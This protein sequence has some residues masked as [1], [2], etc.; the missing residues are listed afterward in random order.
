MR[1]LLATPHTDRSPREIPPTAPAGGFV[2]GPPPF[3][4]SRRSCPIGT[5][6]YS[7]NGQ[8][9]MRA[10]ANVGTL[11]AQIV[12][13]RDPIYS[14]SGRPRDHFGTPLTRIMRHG[15]HLR[16]HWGSSCAAPGPFLSACPSRGPCPIGSSTCRFITQWGNYHAR[17]DPFQHTHHM[18]RAN[19]RTPPTTVVGG[20]VCEPRPMSAHPSHGSCPIRSSIYG[21][22]GRVRMRANANLGTP[23]TRIVLH[24]VLRW[25]AGSHASLRRNRRTPYT[26]RAPYGAP[27]A[28][29]VGKFACGPA[30]THA[31]TPLTRIVP[32]GSSTY[33][34]RGQVRM[35]SP[36]T[37][38]HPYR[39]SFPKWSSIYGPSRKVCVRGHVHVG[40]PL[41]RIVAERDFLRLHWAGRAHMRTRACLFRHTPYTDRVHQGPP[42]TASVGVLEPI[43]AHPLPGSWPKRCSTYCPSG[44]PRMRSR[45]DFGIPSQC[46]CPIGSSSTVP[47]GVL[48]CSPQASSPHPSGESC[49]IRSSTPAPVGGFACGPRPISAPRR[50]SHLRPQ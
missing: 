8:V 7:P 4:A 20:F 14:T 22:S 27:L 36:S 31:S 49:P 11:H 24:S 48:A 45:A 5:S 17:P 50:E 43:S 34:P 28:D 44:R 1:P 41:T 16:P 37:S 32:T 40:V 46:S 19:Q 33:G 9:R 12:P 47:V 42:P 10:R 13:R 35:R 39:G 2:C 18:G 23:L 26:D 3:P 25:F 29:P 30:S 21:P 38:A 6:T 15:P